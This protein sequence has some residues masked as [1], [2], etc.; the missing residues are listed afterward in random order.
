MAGDLLYTDD[1]CCPHCGERAGQQP[2]G[3]PQSVSGHTR[4]ARMR[5]TACGATYCL[6]L[7]ERRRRLPAL[8]PRSKKPRRE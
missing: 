4:I 2:S 8:P 1:L 7:F 3:M 5:C 6:R